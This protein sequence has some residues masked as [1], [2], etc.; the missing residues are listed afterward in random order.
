MTSTDFLIFSLALMPSLLAA[1]IWW[2]V[3][4]IGE[5]LS[6]ICAAD[7]HRFED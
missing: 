5:D 3:T 7:P 4:H 1:H 6:G 2:Y